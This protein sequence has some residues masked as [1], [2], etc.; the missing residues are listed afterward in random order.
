MLVDV[1]GVLKGYSLGQFFGRLAEEYLW[2]IIRSWPGL[3]GV[4]FRYLFLK[5][6]TRRLDGF[7]WIAQGCQIVNCHNLSIGRN[8]ATSRNVLIDA[9][10][11]IEIGDDTGVGP[12]SVIISHEHA[13]MSQGGHFG[14][15]ARRLRAIRLGSRVW[16]GANTF[17]KAGV[18]I[19]DDAVV[20]ACSNVIEDVPP[21]GRVIGSPARPYFEVLRETRSRK[22]RGP[23]ESGPGGTA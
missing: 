22:A 3:E 8:F 17:I 19:G 16:I 13:M 7:C 11:G 10:G 6:V 1:R 20:G 5:L 21:R 4:W 2:W 14:P 15:K 9:L 23:A 18:A 12:N